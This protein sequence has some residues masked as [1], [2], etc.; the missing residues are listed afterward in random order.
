MEQSVPKRR[1]IKFGRRGI[2]QK[3]AYNMVSNSKPLVPILSQINV[4]HTLILFIDGSYYRPTYVGDTVSH[5]YKTTGT[6]IVLHT[7]IYISIYYL[8]I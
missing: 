3:K 1:H 4:V 7:V 6:T 5:L 2:T 8:Q